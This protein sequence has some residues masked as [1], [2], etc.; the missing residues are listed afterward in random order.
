MDK[1]TQNLEKIRGIVKDRPKICQQ[2]QELFALCERLN[3]SRDPLKCEN[4]LKGLFFC[5]RNRA[6]L[7]I[8]YE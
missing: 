2:E 1:Y 8:N 4:G 7:L 6:G 5:L 3:N